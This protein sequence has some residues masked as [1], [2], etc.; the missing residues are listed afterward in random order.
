MILVGYDLYVVVWAIQVWL[1]C[2]I[3]MLAWPMPRVISIHKKIMVWLTC[4]TFGKVTTRVTALE[5]TLNIM[6]TNLSTLFEQLL[7]HYASAVL[8]AAK[9]GGATSVVTPPV[10]PSPLVGP[11][12][13]PQ[14]RKHLC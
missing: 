7:A 2:Q 12:A 6:N 4:K 9:S 10:V 13:P 5:G 1:V 14:H 11:S 8:D 3:R